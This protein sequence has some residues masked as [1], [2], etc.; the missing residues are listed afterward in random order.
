M[1]AYN[2]S[3]WSSKAFNT[4]QRIFKMIHFQ[5]QSLQDTW[6]EKPTRMHPETFLFTLLKNTEVHKEDKIFFSKSHEEDK[7]CMPAS[8]G[9]M[10]HIW[11]PMKSNP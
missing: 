11:Q 2:L 3:K 7:T 1:A 10:C 6:Q 8:R 5:L 9:Q 4:I